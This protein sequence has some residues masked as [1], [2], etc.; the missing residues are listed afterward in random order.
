MRIFEFT[1]QKNERNPVERKNKVLVAR[2]TGAIEKDAKYALGLFA[3]EFGNLKKNTI[4][5]IIEVDNDG[6]QIGEPITPVENS[7][8]IV[9]TRR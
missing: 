2:P 1:W 4:I 8:A 7:E 6:K 9:P 5:S 3:T